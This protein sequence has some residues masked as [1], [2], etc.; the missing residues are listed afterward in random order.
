MPPIIFFWVEYKIYYLDQFYGLIDGLS[1]SIFIHR[2]FI[3]PIM[4]SEHKVMVFKSFDYFPLLTLYVIGV[5]FFFLHILCTQIPKMVP[6]MFSM[7]HDI[8]INCSWTQNWLRSKKWYPPKLY[9][10]QNYILNCLSCNYFIRALFCTHNRSLE[11]SH[12]DIL[13]KKKK[14]YLVCLEVVV[15]WNLYS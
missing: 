5:F 15:K 14:L 12:R 1:S 3:F 6:W 2:I 13:F 7:V 11:S 4:S 9:R 8:S 10:C